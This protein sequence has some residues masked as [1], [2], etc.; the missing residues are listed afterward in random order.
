[1]KLKTLIERLKENI[2]A[3]KLAR[4]IATAPLVG[5]AVQ[6][7][8]EEQPKEAEKPAIEQQI[9][10]PAKPKITGYASTKFASDYVAPHGSVLKGEVNQS[11]INLNLGRFSGFVWSNYDFAAGEF[12][13]VDVGLSYLIPLTE[14]ISFR[15]GA[16]RWEYPSGAFGNHD[17][18]LKAGANYN[19]PLNIDLDITHLINNYQTGTGIRFRGKVSK[20]FPLGEYK[21]MKFSVTPG[22]TTAEVINYYGLHGL[23]HVTPSVSLGL[24][25]GKFGLELSVNRQFGLIDEVEQAHTWGG[26]NLGVSF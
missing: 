18:V 6:A 13:E 22:I 10:V 8:A 14:K 16:E 26:V 11:L 21:G 19:G 24:Q 3:R 4:A 7:V 20:K 15:A 23:S 25:K 5:A 1:M 9:Q 2:N 17:N 12:N